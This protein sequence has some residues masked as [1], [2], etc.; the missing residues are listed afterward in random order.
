V[1]TWQPD[2]RGD[3]SPR[4][5]SGGPSW[6]GKRAI[7]DRMSAPVQL[8]AD[9]VATGER[10][11]ESATAIAAR[12]TGG[13]GGP[14]PHLAAIQ[15]AFG[16]HDVSAIRAHVGGEAAAAARDLG[17]LAYA[18]GDHVAFAAPPDLHTTAHEAAHVVQQ[19]AGVFL[20]DGL[21]DTGDI[22]ERNADAV[23]DRVV[24][25]RTAE[26]LLP[27]TTGTAAPSTAVQRLNGA[28]PAN[29]RVTAVTRNDA[30][31]SVST[32]LAWD[33]SDGNQANLADFQTREQIVF[34]ANPAV[35]IPAYGNPGLLPPGMAI[36]GNTLTKPVGPM[37]NPGGHDKHSGAALGPKFTVGGIANLQRAAWTLVGTQHYQASQA[38]GP[39]ANVAGPFVITRTM[40]HTPGG[41]PH[42]QDLYELRIS[43]IGPNCAIAAGPT[44]ITLETSTAIGA[45]GAARQD[46]TAAWN[47][48]NAAF[49]AQNLA[50]NPIATDVR[51][52]ATGTAITIDYE[53]TSPDP[54]D[55]HVDMLTVPPAWLAQIVARAR[56]AVSHVIDEALSG[57]NPPTQFR[58]T[59]FRANGVQQQ[60]FW[61]NENGGTHRII[62]R[63]EKLMDMTSWGRDRDTSMAGRESKRAWTDKGKRGNFT[64]GVVTHELG[65]LV[66]AHSAGNTYLT[67]TMMPDMIPAL[68]AGADP[69]ADEKIQ[70]ATVNGAVIHALAA[71]GYKAKWGYAL[72]NPGEVVPEVFA[73]IM[74]GRTVPKGMAAVYVAYGGQRSATIDAALATA[75]GGAVPVIAE[76]EDCIPIIDN[77]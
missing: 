77:S 9:G 19:R 36:A 69:L 50:M 43:K 26:D 41:G 29:F 63:A 23:A 12:G 61:T 31:C 18:H 24:A 22:Y 62:L 49:T 2:V 35:A 46:Q 47:T 51:N 27:A 70:I 11:S 48:A 58:I 57:A 76:P 66:H 72:N 53:H 75:F 28:N 40:T 74:K 32:D 64:E 30:E 17:A 37:S 15:R 42:G 44:P 21:G 45:V 73:A 54:N 59:I 38:G 5:A 6:P 33:S 7:T 56:A 71:K 55:P 68:M 34:G 8:R 16:R 3:D 4:A 25:G 39:W 65:H 52:N 1:K 13:G 10:P 14:L 20:T 67:A 60:A